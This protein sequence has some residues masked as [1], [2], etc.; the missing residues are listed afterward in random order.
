MDRT[1]NQCDRSLVASSY[2]ILHFF[3]LSVVVLCRMYEAELKA[4]G[5]RF[6][7]AHKVTKPI[8][9]VNKPLNEHLGTL[10]IGCDQC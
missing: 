5:H 9:N 7:G 10:Q 6:S 1:T 4:F 8:S 3:S 2:V